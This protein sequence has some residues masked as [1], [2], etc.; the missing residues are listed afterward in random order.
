MPAQVTPSSTHVSPRGL[1][2]R[3]D[4]NCVDDFDGVSGL[5]EVDRDFID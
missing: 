4:L 5:G 1:G 2:E 3:D